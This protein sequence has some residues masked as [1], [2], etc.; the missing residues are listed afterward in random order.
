MITD[1][2]FYYI[3][4][5]GVDVPFYHQEMNPSYEEDMLN[6][7][8]DIHPDLTFFHGVMNERIEYFIL[9]QPYDDPDLFKT[10]THNLYFEGK[11]KERFK[12][13]MR[14]T[15]QKEFAFGLGTNRHGHGEVSEYD[16]WEGYYVKP[17][18]KKLIDATPHQKQALHVY[19]LTVV[20]PCFNYQINFFDYKHNLKYVQARLIGMTKEAYMRFDDECVKIFPSFKDEKNAYNEE[21]GII[22]ADFFQ[23]HL[24]NNI[25]SFTTTRVNK[26]LPS[27][28]QDLSLPILI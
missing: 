4:P 25:Q 16:L 17:S 28:L 2:K 5:T 14:Y 15:K 21:S 8:K 27:D 23:R 3:R 20:H 10:V 24:T 18:D 6:I 9:R 13:S 12:D 22:H 1:R 7:V 26:Y 11:L 19:D